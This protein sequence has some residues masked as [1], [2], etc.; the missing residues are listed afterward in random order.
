MVSNVNLVSEIGDIAKA[1]NESEAKVIAEAIKIGIDKLWK[2]SIIDK[3]LNGK[4]S[5]RKATNLV[6]EA[7]ILMAEKQKKAVIDDLRWGLSNA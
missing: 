7:L 6:G 3:Y 1:R 2:E 5:K 4:I